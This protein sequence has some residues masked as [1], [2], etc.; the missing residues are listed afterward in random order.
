MGV[1]GSAGA[2]SLSAAEML[3]FVS[4][5]SLAAVH[6]RFQ[7]ALGS[8]HQLCCS[9][10]GKAGGGGKWCPSSPSVA[11]CAPS[12]PNSRWG[13]VPSSC[14]TL[15]QPESPSPPWKGYHEQLA[16]GVLVQLWLSLPARHLFQLAGFGVPAPR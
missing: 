11:A 15:N 1:Q 2:S 13:I 6:E 4:S 14:P 12:I 5:G 10:R 9:I 16:L 3:G 8:W 7:M